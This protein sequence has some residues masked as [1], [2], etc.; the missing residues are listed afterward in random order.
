MRSY[1]ILILSGHNVTIEGNDEMIIFYFEG[2]KGWIE[3]STGFV[4][5]NGTG[6]S[7]ACARGELRKKIEEA[8]K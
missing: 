3:V 2:K 7:V 8:L 1:V 6:F 4:Q 5:W